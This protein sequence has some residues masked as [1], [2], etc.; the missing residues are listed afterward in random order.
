MRRLDWRFR[1]LVDGLGALLSNDQP[2]TRELV[3]VEID[4]ASGGTQEIPDDYKDTRAVTGWFGCSRHQLRA[5][6]LAGKIRCKFVGGV[7]WW[8]VMDVEEEVTQRG[9]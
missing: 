6:R 8:N 2:L 1:M 5:M 9:L 4:R 3:Q 7:W